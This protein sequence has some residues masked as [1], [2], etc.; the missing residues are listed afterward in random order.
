MKKTSCIA[1]AV[2]L[3]GAAGF[4]L[5]FGFGP[6]LAAA[7][8]MLAAWAASAQPAGG[9]RPIRT[10]APRHSRETSRLRRRARGIV[11]RCH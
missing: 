7:L 10:T 1:G 9:P 11:I 3:P 4:A 5:G 2:V 8:L 6:K